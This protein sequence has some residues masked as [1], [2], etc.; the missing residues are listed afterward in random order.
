MIKKRGNKWV[1]YSESGRRLGV[2]DTRE[3]A[4]KR[5]RQIEFFKHKKKR[6]K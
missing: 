6:N 4:E 2:E 5:L 3:E 1:I